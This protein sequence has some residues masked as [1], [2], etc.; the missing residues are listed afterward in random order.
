[1][2]CIVV[3]FPASRPVPDRS[4]GGIFVMRLLLLF[5]V[6]R[7]IITNSITITSVR[8]LIF[9]DVLWFFRGSALSQIVSHRPENAADQASRRDDIVLPFVGIAFKGHFDVGMARD[10]L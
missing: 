5:Q 4:R 2:P 6:I 7:P 1:M 8:H 3:K 10:G 9:P